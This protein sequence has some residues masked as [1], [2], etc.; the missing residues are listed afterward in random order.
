MN[1]DIKYNVLIIGLGNIGMKYD[2]LDNSNKKILTHSKSFFSNQK[3]ELVG[4]IDLN[5]K[6]R[7]NF[8]ERYKCKSF[9]NI[10]EASFDVNPDI[11][12]VSTPTNQ[13]YE[14]IDDNACYAYFS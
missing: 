9:K 7:T 5:D 2:L 10:K 13:H 6:N 3:F 14:N 4:G 11:I 12:V 1:F 8:E